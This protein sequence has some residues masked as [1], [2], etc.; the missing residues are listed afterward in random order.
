VQLLTHIEYEAGDNI[1]AFS[2]CKI[3]ASQ[4]V[5]NALVV[6]YFMQVEDHQ[7]PP[8]TAKLVD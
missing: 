8:E 1:I 7:P 3:F 5:C 4:E 6:N 2:G